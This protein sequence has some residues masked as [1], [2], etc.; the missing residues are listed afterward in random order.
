MQQ[1]ILFRFRNR[2]RLITHKIYWSTTIQIAVASTD[3]MN[4]D[5]HF[6]KADYFLIFEKT[7]EGLVQAGSRKVNPLSEN[8]PMHDFNLERFMKIALQLQG[9]EQVYV[10]KIGEKPARKLANLGIEPIVYQGP[11]KDI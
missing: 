6:G 10:T 8:D 2:L 4:V 11:I 5:Q 1:G 3:G 9:C 7:S